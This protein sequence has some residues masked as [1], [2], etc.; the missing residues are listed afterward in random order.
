MQIAL[1]IRAGEK[2]KEYKL[3]TYNVGKDGD[4]VQDMILLQ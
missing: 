2:N 1:P 3:T 4:E